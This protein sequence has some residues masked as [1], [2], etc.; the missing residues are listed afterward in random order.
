MGQDVQCPQ[1]HATFVAGSTSESK[2]VAAAETYSL[3]PERPPERSVPA[4]EDEDFHAG[5]DYEDQDDP[6]WRRR[7][8]NARR[9]DALARVAAPAIML[10][11]VGGLAIA[12]SIVGLGINV[13][14]AGMQAGMNAQGPR[15]PGQFGPGPRNTMDPMANVVLGIFGAVLGL[16]WGGMVLLGGLKLKNLESHGLAMTG[17]ILAMIPCNICCILGLP[18]GIYALVVMNS[19]DV[20][21]QFR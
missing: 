14:S 9:Q 2:P 12:L 15:Q 19:A 5:R 1:C 8:K 7:R 16:C 4:P 21:D 20:R 18:L 13:L 6:E 3:Q 11:I 10:M 17:A